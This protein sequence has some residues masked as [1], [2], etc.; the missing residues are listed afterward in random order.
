MGTRNLTAVYIDGEYK[1]AQYGQWDGYPEGQGITCLRF[2]KN[3]MQED[4]FKTKV[5]GLRYL[6]SETVD[7]IVEKCKLE[8]SRWAVEYPQLTRDTGA[9]IL[10]YIQNGHCEI[11]RAHV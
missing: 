10:Q 4:L 6:S 5:R 11:G 3:N 9:E 7:G 8:G 1:V 2:L